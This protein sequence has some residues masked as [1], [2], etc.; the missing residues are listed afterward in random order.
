MLE[1]REAGGGR[2]TFELGRARGGGGGRDAEHRGGGV[3]HAADDPPAAGAPG[4]DRERQDG[5]G[6]VE[7]DAVGQPGEQEATED[8]RGERDGEDRLDGTDD[9]PR[10]DRREPCPRAWCLGVHRSHQSINA[11][12]VRIVSCSRPARVPANHRCRAAAVA[13]SVASSAAIRSRVHRRTTLG[14]SATTSAVRAAP[15]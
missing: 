6:E 5:R 13:G 14:A 1:V 4:E 7:A 15:V 8:E 9:Q 11:S 3:L 12:K 2:H 10:R